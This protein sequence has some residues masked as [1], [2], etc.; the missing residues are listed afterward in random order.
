M[1]VILQD[2]RDRGLGITEPEILK[3]PPDVSLFRVTHSPNPF[4]K[5]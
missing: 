5:N 2:I 1:A 3:K 4:P